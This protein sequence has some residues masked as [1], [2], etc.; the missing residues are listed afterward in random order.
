[1]VGAVQDTFN[2]LRKSEWTSHACELETSMYL[3]S[4]PEYVYMQKAR[5]DIDPHVSSHFWSDLAGKAQFRVRP[6]CF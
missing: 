4:Q 1:M 2:A 3:A 5:R 6:S